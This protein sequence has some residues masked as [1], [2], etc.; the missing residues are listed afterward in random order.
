MS[1]IFE[2]TSSRVKLDMLKLTSGILD[3][4]RE[5]QKSDL[6][7]VDKL[8]LIIQ[9]RSGDFQIDENGIL[10][11]R[12]RVCVPDIADLRKRILEEGHRSGLN[13]HPGVTKMYQDLRKLFRW[14]SMKKEIV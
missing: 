6:T 12:D 9:G 11:C 1:L 13:I 14:P 3:E 7:L 4:I 5:G 8:T 10:R 2:E